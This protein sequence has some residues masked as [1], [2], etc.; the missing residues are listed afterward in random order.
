MV[1]NYSSWSVDKLNKELEKIQR[2]IKTKE[3][4]D[5]KATLA[6][7]VLVARKSGLIA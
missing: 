4:R 1:T 7:L 6:K 5:K 3:A 2:V